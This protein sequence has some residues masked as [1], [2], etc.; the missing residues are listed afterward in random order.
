MV[1][2]LCAARNSQVCREK[3][4]KDFNMLVKKYNFHYWNKFFEMQKTKRIN[5]QIYFRMTKYLN[6]SQSAEFV[7]DFNRTEG[8]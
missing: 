5:F 1:L 7:S 4:S 6:V 3:F 8:V 2:N